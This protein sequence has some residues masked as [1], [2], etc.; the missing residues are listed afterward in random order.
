MTLVRRNIFLRSFFIVVLLVGLSIIVFFVNILSA[1]DNE[2]LLNH[3]YIIG[4]VTVEFVIAIVIAVLYMRLFQKSAEIDIFF[5]ILA[6]LLAASDI[7]KLTQIMLL[8][9][10][11][12]HLMPTVSRIIITGHTLCIMALFAASA[13]AGGIRMQR[14]GT[15]IFVVVA[16][17]IVLI[18]MIP[19]YT[20]HLPA[21]LVHDVGIRRSFAVSLRLLLL[22]AVFNYFYYSAVINRNW[23]KAVM[24]CAIGLIALGR[25]FSFTAKTWN[26][27]R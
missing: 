16:I 3:K 15:A 17:V 10:A 7:L 4:A 8:L 21:N 19:L 11:L 20:E 26:F 27:L 1:A 5:V 9:E 13:Y 6:F 14:H 25:S 22:A 18:T 23:R 12:P 24:A 2:L